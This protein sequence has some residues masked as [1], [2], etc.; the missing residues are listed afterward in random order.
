MPPQRIWLKHTL[1]SALGVTLAAA[2]MAACPAMAQAP[3]SVKPAAQTQAQAQNSDMMAG[4]EAWR[5][6][7]D[8]AAVRAWQPLAERGNADAQFNMGQAFKLGRGVAQDI[9]MAEIWYRRAASQGHLQAED[10]L[11]L[12][13]FASGQRGAAMHYIRKSAARGEA[14]AL[15]L[16]GTAHFNG[17]LAP[18]DWPRAYALTLRASQTGLSL[19]ASRV[20]ELDKLI[21]QEQRDQGLAL[22][23][24]LVRAE[25]EARQ[26]AT[27]TIA[28][29][30]PANGKNNAPP[31]QS[32]STPPENI[33]RPGVAPA[34]PIQMVDIAPSVMQANLDAAELIEPEMR[35]AARP[36]AGVTF[37]PPPLPAPRSST[38]V[39]EAAPEAAPQAAPKAPPAPAAATP[40]APAAK[41]SA[42]KSSIVPPADSLAENEQADAG[43]PTQPKII[44]LPPSNSAPQATPPAAAPEPA[45]EPVS[46]PAA[47][48][49]PTTNTA[50]A[51]PPPATKPAPKPASKAASA[52]G[53]WRLQLG[54]F[55]QSGNAQRMWSQL[56]AQHQGIA[57]RKPIITSNGRLT[58]LY[59]GEFSSRADAVNLCN[60]LK[61]N[62]QSCIVLD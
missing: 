11:G 32:T 24:Q 49:V 8:I 44:D 13:L 20:A 57:R 5:R 7:D 17:D 37:T 42:P 31:A 46:A 53:P 41:A 3:S 10:N 27:G 47:A 26:A 12:I 30:A 28:A 2:I 48:P 60:Q 51:A 21:P 19:A 14:R 23:P 1:P 56:S 25:E 52:T 22:I 40:T 15:F 29:V 18:Q 62:N 45:P 59:A 43:P 39:P 6:G 55:S 16:L 38:L 4:A 36:K 58:M 35:P 34:A 33:A 54:A 9:A 50:P 61:S